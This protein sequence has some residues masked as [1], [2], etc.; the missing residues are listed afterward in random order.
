MAAF[1]R[2]SRATV[3][4]LNLK[5][6]PLT[7]SDLKELGTFPGLTRLGATQ[8]GAASE[9]PEF[10]ELIASSCPHLRSIFVKLD[11]A[12]MEEVLAAA[13]EGLAACRELQS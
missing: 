1:L 13:F 7:V 9:L 5:G 4:H 10:L 8:Q 6:T 11:E 3:V 2:P 12:I